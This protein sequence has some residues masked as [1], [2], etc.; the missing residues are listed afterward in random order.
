MIITPSLQARSRLL[1]WPKILMRSA[2]MFF[3][4]T[5][6]LEKIIFVLLND[7]VLWNCYFSIYFTLMI[8]QKNSMLLPLFLCI[9]FTDIFSISLLFFMYNR[10]VD[11]YCIQDTELAQDTKEAYLEITKAWPKVSQKK[12]RIR[13]PVARASPEVV[14]NFGLPPRTY[15]NGPNPGPASPK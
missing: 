2:R 5:F 14:R 13:I 12:K 10:D 1:P 11:G 4:C 3:F 7:L 8:L 15:F 9:I 6:G